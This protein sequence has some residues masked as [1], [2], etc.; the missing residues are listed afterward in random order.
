[1]PAVARGIPKV[2]SGSD[3]LDT[4]VRW[5]H[6]SEL[7][8]VAG[9]LSGG[10]LILSIGIVLA[11]PGTDLAAYVDSL[12]DSG[13]A[14]LA[15]ELGRH[16]ERLPDALVQAARAHGFPVIELHAPV[17]FVEI[18]E[19]VHAQ[20]VNAQFERLSFSHRAHRA[21]GTL[22]VEG[23]SAEEILG[24]CVDLISRPVV[25]EDLAHRVIAFD[26]DVPAEDI[27]R[28]WS[29]RSRQVPVGPE[30]TYGGPEQWISTPVGPRRRR[31]GRL[32]VPTRIGRA[33]FDDV[34]FVLERAAEAV[35]ITHLVAN[36]AEGTEGAAAAKLIQDVL[37]GHAADPVV[38]RARARALGFAT[39]GPIAVVM[40]RGPGADDDPDRDLVDG[41]TKAA[42]AVQRSALVGRV[43]P[44]MVA[45]LFDCPLPESAQRLPERL[46]EKLGDGL[47]AAL[48]AGQP[49]QSWRDLPMSLTEAEHVATVAPAVPGTTRPGVVRARDLGIRSLLWQIRDDSRLHSF[50]ESRLGPVLALRSDK[51]EETLHLLEAYLQENGVMV[52]F[53][54]RVHLGR[55]AAYARVRSLE[56]LL[57]SNLSD[58]EE[59]TSVHVALIAYRQD[60][61]RQ[62]P[63]SPAQPAR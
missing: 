26:G 36:T 40:A 62:L 27:L 19:T 49:A 32:V 47:V 42:K 15:V 63:S 30:T 2:R 20:V 8:N 1:M 7:A 52:P 38:V 24:R 33:H 55:T 56:R 35:T 17:R 5:V 50:I 6:V 21:L 4:E 18:T 10:E 39:S 48:A 44:Q 13:A 41:V 28:D 14:G 58:S 11:E 23:A 12:R 31:W 61:S 59:R 34:R 51:R 57:Q 25:L 60:D 46:V 22:G 43:R 45:V 53:A 3:A 54:R 37:S 16:V 9:T 29:S